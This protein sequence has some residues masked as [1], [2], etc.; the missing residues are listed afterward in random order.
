MR[1]R[2]FSSSE[3]S[4]DK[5]IIY[6]KQQL[7]GLEILLDQNA[8]LEEEVNRLCS[9]LDNATHQVIQRG[10]LYKWREREIGWA[11][12]WV[13]RYFTLQGSILSYYIDEHERRPKRTLDLSRCVVRQEG[14]KKQ[15]KHLPPSL[16]TSL[17]SRITIRIMILDSR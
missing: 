9:E 8:R 5:E 12:K 14:T 13:L 6:L 17:L 15:G 4:K 11:A 10:Y 2:T 16:D 3:A 7:T 1:N